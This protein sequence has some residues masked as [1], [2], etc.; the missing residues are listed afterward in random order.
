MRAIFSY[1]K[2]WTDEQGKPLKRLE[3]TVSNS[4]KREPDYSEFVKNCIKNAGNRKEPEPEKAEIKHSEDKETE[5][6]FR[7]G[8]LDTGL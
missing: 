1:D 8:Y 6:I 5:I 2:G 3:K 7:I 4:P